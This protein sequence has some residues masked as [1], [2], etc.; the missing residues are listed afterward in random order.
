M[1]PLPPS[2]FPLP[3]TMKAPGDRRKGIWREGVLQIW[4]TRACDKACV[5]CTQGSN[6]AGPYGRMTPEQ[7]DAACRSL[8]GYFGVVGVFGGNPTLHPQFE[9]LCDILAHHFP[10]EQRGLWT[11]KLHG[12]GT[13]ARRTFNPAYS[14]L[15]VHLDQAAYDEFRRDWPEARPKGLDGDSRHSPPYVAMKDVIADEAE[16]WGLIANCDV[17]QL[18]SALIGVFRGELRAWFCELA[19]AQAMLHQHEPDY[20]D[21][22]LP[23]VPGWWEQPLR[24][25]EAQVRHHCHACGIPLR[26]AGDLAVGGTVEQV[27]ETHAAVYRPKLKGREVRLVTSRT[28]LG[29]VGRATDY[30]EN[31]AETAPVAPAGPRKRAIDGLV[32]CVGAVYAAQLA[33]SLPVWLDTLDSLTVVTAPGDPDVLP[34][35]ALHRARPNLRVVET[36]LFSRHGAHFNKGAALSHALAQMR[37][38]DWVLHFDADI[39]PSPTW[40]AVAEPLLEPGNLHGADRWFENGRLIHDT[41]FPAGYFQLWHVDDPRAQ[42]RPLFDVH[43][44]HAGNYDTFFLE[45]WPEAARRKLEIRLTHLGAPR[46]NWFGV[47]RRDK[48]L[49]RDGL[50]RMQR[51]H[52]IGLRAALHQDTKVPV[53]PPRVR[54]RI[55]PGGDPAWLRGIVRLCTPADPFAVRASVSA[56]AA[57]PVPGLVDLVIPAG[58]PE[59]EVRQALEAA[60]ASTAAPTTTEPTTS[61][62]AAPPRPRATLERAAARRVAAPRPAAAPRPTRPPMPAAPTA[63]TPDDVRYAC[64]CV[65]RVDREWG[66][67]RAVRK[68]RRHRPTPPQ[69]RARPHYT[70][71]CGV[72]TRAGIPRHAVYIREL[73]DALVELDVRIPRATSADPDHPPRVLEVGCGFGQYAPLFMR[74][75]YVYEGLEANPYAADWT[76]GAFDVTVHRGPFEAFGAAGGTYAAIHAAHVLE[77]FDDAPRMAAKMFDLLAPGGRLYL[78][79]PDDSDPVNPDHQ[80]FFTEAGLTAL[81]NRV[82]FADVRATARQIV[83]HEKFIYVVAERP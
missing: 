12:K 71:E 41:P 67:L 60:L 78:V 58:M 36:D 65:N 53:P 7:F 11:N 14:N 63:P 4:V 83:A 50:R 44:G 23:V 1:P 31:G 49:E 61:R 22:G 27:S 66:I 24:A 68:C 2:S 47:G 21:L 40:R 33:R 56:E 52:K 81:L 82:G 43:W 18:W 57:E 37:P 25:F 32:T 20:P 5:G 76:A 70:E 34:V 29:R 62:S 26:G 28:E 15:N 6:L 51:L 74:H 48:G 54:V 16:R 75:G 35:L 39:L 59:E 8:K 69:A 77:H 10:K 46:R 64:G 38:E 42:L 17:N 9:E 30:I 13:I 55:E 19:G 73:L 80:W 72:L 3:A 45:R 79:V